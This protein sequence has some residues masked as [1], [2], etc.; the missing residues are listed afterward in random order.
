MTPHQLSVFI[1]RAGVKAA[2]T[3]MAADKK[4]GYADALFAIIGET[5]D[6]SPM[7]SATATVLYEEYTDAV[8]Y[9]AQMLLRMAHGN[10]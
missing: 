4:N 9:G 8:N 2:A 10:N 5:A 1:L 7:V 6:V 3:E